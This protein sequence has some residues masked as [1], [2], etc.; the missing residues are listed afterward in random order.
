M[1]CLNLMYVFIIF[2]EIENEMQSFAETFPSIILFGDF[3]ARTKCLNDY[4]ETDDHIFHTTNTE[5]LLNKYN[6]EI[7]YFCKPN[8]SVILKR[9]VIKT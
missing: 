3:N 6:T 1:C 9:I 4:I 8:S 7:E 5:D 2:D